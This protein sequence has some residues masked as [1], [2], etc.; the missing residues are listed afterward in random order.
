M[1]SLQSDLNYLADVNAGIITAMQTV[2][3]KA[4]W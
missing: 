2:D 1:R 3:P 4:I